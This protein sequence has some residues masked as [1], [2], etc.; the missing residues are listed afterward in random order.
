[1]GRLS[2]DRVPPHGLWVRGEG[3]LRHLC[4]RS[5]AVVGARSATP[6]GEHV[7]SE[8]AYTLGEHSVVTVSGGADGIDGAA[9]RAAIAVG[10]TVVVLACGLDVDYPRGHAALFADVARGGV[11]VSERRLGTTPRGPDGVIRD[12]RVAA[13]RR[14]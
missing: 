11:L 2:E 5:V 14:G 1:P 9:H 3:D 13:V 7:A 12:T 6:Y 10:A 4:L 8:M